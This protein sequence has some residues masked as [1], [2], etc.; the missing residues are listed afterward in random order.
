MHFQGVN[1]NKT[2]NFGKPGGGFGAT[3]GTGFGSNTAGGFGGTAGAFGAKPGGGFGAS[4]GTGFGSTTAGGFG[5]ATAGGFGQ[6]TQTGGGFG[7]TGTG[8]GSTS[9]AS[10]ALTAKPGTGSLSS[11]FSLNSAGKTGFGMGAG[12]T[13]FG[14]AGGFGGFGATSTSTNNFGG[15][16]ATSFANTGFG[17][18]A[19]GFGNTSLVTTSN[20]MGSNLSAADQA[21]REQLRFK[22]NEENKKAYGVDLWSDRYRSVEKTIALNNEFL[23]TMYRHKPQEVQQLAK[24]GGVTSDRTNSALNRASNRS[25]VRVIA[26]SIGKPRTPNL[27]SKSKDRNGPNKNAS[28][29]SSSSYLSSPQKD[30]ILSPEKSSF[31]EFK[32]DNEEEDEQKRANEKHVKKTQPD[33]SRE[34]YQPRSN[35]GSL[36]TPS[37]DFRDGL[38][39]RLSSS[40]M[41]V[42]PPIERILQMSKSELSKV[43]NFT[44]MAADGSAKLLWPSATD[45][46]EIDIEKCVSLGKLPNG[47]PYWYVYSGPELEASKL[48]DAPAHGKGLNKQVI[49]TLFM[50]GGFCTDDKAKGEKKIRKCKKTVQKSGYEF[51][52]YDPETGELVFV[53]DD[54]AASV[55]L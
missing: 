16:G 26:R 15:S 34:V 52:S 2:L 4:T 17:K 19:G 47:Q 53:A 1:T 13:S 10:K 32:D 46:L 30:A 29:R 20:T 21:A 38:R 31:F 28:S 6:N 55:T 48:Q 25:G 9:I 37:S 3:T 23:E 39:Q 51:Q 35:P 44:I 24:A 41:K 54:P 14:T 22:I 49:V 18:G 11:G 5:A 27:L 33:D 12:S 36:S 43:E 8:F 45:L 50:P 7:A 40:I 42:E